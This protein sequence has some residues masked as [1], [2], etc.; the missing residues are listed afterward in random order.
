MALTDNLVSY[1]KLESNSNDSHWS[2][3]GTDTSVSYWTGKI[4]NCAN[5]TT[6]SYS[7]MGNVFDME[8][9]QAWTK[10]FWHKTTDSWV[11]LCL[12]TKQNSAYP[13]QW[14][15]T[16]I[17]W[18]KYTQYVYSGSWL[19]LQVRTNSTYNDWNWNFITVTYDGSVD[20]NGILIYV[21]GSLAAT[22]IEFNTIGAFTTLTTNWFQINWRW[23][24]TSQ[25]HTGSIDE[26]WIWTRVLSAS[27]ITELY[28]WWN[29]LT[30]PFTNVKTVDWLAYAS[31]KTI[32]G[33]AIA[34][35]KSVN[36]L[37]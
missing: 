2:N 18:G 29:W 28:N 36:W 21:N 1:Y 31:V 27:E 15:F 30:Y 6:T 33:L 16:L 22:T 19:R 20:A 11:D 10:S 17:N 14:I 13:N 9:T 37:Q 5:Y 23:N 25:T 24:S 7:N 26:V 35:V 3:N 4:W 8:R 32:N 12:L 34:S